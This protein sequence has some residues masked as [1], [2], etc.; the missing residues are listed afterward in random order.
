[1]IHDMVGGGAPLNFKVVGGTSAPASLK[2]NTIW[3]NTDTAITSWAF[4]A[5]QPATA[6]EGMVWFF[7]GTQSSSEFNALKKNGIQV[8]P[9]SAKQ[10]VSGAWVTK[11]AKSYQSGAWVDWCLV[12]VPNTGLRWTESG[13]TVTKNATETVITASVSANS[14]KYAYCVVDL[15]E[16]K[17]LKV[18]GTIGASGTGSSQLTL[19]VGIFKSTSSLV[20][21]FSD[22]VYPGGSRDINNSYDVSSMTGEYQLRVNFS[23]GA[24]AATCTATLT[25][26]LVE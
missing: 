3:V 16:F 10:Y 14:T 9:L 1:M 19:Q 24:S 22:K 6:A 8:Y 17:T 12:L 21:G 26:V 20:T 15:T 5:T 7:T 2:E 23:A 13:A 4:R 11:T 25:S 18:V